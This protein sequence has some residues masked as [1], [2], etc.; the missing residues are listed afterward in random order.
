M[1]TV[2]A[3]MSM[4]M[5]L[6]SITAPTTSYAQEFRALWLKRPVSTAVSVMAPAEKWRTIARV[7]AS[8]N[9][10][11][12]VEYMA[13]PRWITLGREAAALVPGLTSAQMSDL[14]QIPRRDSTFVFAR[15]VPQQSR[16]VI[17]AIR[18]EQRGAYLYLEHAYFSPYHGEHWAASRAFLTENERRDTSRAGR[19]PF[20]AFMHTS[21]ADPTFHNVGWDAALVATGKAMKHFGAAYSVVSVQNLK[22]TQSQETSGGLLTKK[23]TIKV[24]GY[25]VPTWFVGLPT[26][27][28]TWGH[29]AA[30]CVVPT[31]DA[32]HPDTGELMSNGCPDPALVAYSGVSFDQAKG[33]LFPS[34]EEHIYHWEKTEGGFTVL[35]F[36][37][38]IMAA[39]FFA[40]PQLFAMVTDV[41]LGTTIGGLSGV[42]AAAIA[43]TAYAGG[44]II[45]TS[46]PASLTDVKEG[47]FGS[48]G[49][50]VRLADEQSS[51]QQK[52]AS[53]ILVER[54]LKEELTSVCGATGLLC[55][56]KSVANSVTPQL[57]TVQFGGH[58]QGVRTRL[59]YCMQTL[60]LPATSE[61]VQKCLVPPNPPIEVP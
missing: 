8:T 61:A 47:V 26:T 34:G 25:A 52:N 40:G 42:E 44:S 28:Q 58:Q 19:N 31:V 12:S 60:G 21:R 27:V 11:F 39:A 51:Q 7:R 59:S 38:V 5:L 32:Y 16:L 43:G 54:H 10:R 23:T 14:M 3:A 37:A 17:N 46:G 48:I 29:S 56:T 1:K 45:T 18:V 4:V 36:T 33:T 20:A 2:A 22:M 57:N 13:G 50:G 53:Q 35:F 24:E 6:T 41:G 55:N 15:Y 49:S 30:I 9:E